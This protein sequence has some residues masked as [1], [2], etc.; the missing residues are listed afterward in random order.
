M[1]GKNLPIIVVMQ[2]DSDIKQNIGRGGV[3]FFG[4]VTP[5]VQTKVCQDLEN[6]QNYYKDV[7]EENDKVP[8]V[9]KV[10]VKEEAIAKS[11]KPQDLFRYCPI[12]GTADLNEIYV[13]VT[14]KGIENTIALTKMP[15]S[16]KVK[17]NL[18]VVKEILPINTDDVISKNL[19]INS[20]LYTLNT[21]KN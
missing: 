11:H 5:E 2:K 15:T 4:D 9:G 12:I 14:K 20:F 19:L 8:A 18:T 1:E 10:V 21:P 16:E 17:A 13:K 7:F 3:K 6:V